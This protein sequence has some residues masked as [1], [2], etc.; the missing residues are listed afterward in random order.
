ML[1]PRSADA[2]A[3][4]IRMRRSSCPIW[5]NQIERLCS[6]LKDCNGS[7]PGTARRPQ[8][9]SASSALRQLCSGRPLSATPKAS[10]H[11]I[12]LHLQRMEW[13]ENGND[14]WTFGL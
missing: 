14:A 2:S 6:E 11:R 9:I 10:R 5:R 4:V 1:L 3:P 13:S 7:L 12:R 8:P